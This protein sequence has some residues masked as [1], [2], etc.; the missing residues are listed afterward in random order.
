[1][2][3]H[4]SLQCKIFQRTFENG[5]AAGSR[6][7]RVR[8]TKFLHNSSIIFANLFLEYF[9]SF[10]LILNGCM[11]KTCLKL[12][13]L[14]NRVST[15]GFWGV[16]LCRGIFIKVFLQYSQYSLLVLIKTAARK[17]EVV[18]NPETWFGKIL[19]PYMHVSSSWQVHTDILFNIHLST[20]EKQIYLD[21]STLLMNLWNIVLIWNTWTRQ[22]INCSPKFLRSQ[23]LICTDLDLDHPEI[24]H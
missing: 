14:Q 16:C 10:F 8:R 24:G 13:F 15:L 1:M 4:Q 17:W 19:C 23:R 20:S 18:R 11:I 3:I 12:F 6:Y 2:E 7:E 22:L 21:V 9:F 5:L